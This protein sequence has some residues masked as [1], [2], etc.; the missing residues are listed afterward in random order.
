MDD[1][2]EIGRHL[3][4]KQKTV[5]DLPVRLGAREQVPCRL[6]AVRVPETVAQQR[7]RKL[8]RA[9][10]KKGQTPSAAQLELATWSLFV[11]NVPTERLTLDEALVLARAR[12]Q[13]ELLFKLW[14][15]HGQ[16]DTWRSQNSWRILCEVYAK[17]LAQLVQH[18]LLLVSCWEY[19]DRSLVKAAQT[20]A[21]LAFALT[22]ALGC[23]QALEEVVRLLQRCLAG[24]GRMNKR[25]TR[26]NTCQLLGNPPL[27][28][29][30]T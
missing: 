18:W 9:A 3:Q 22:A 11:T 25:K 15:S 21:R 13:I 2:V 10:Q 14:K 26:P 30:L 12:W 29:G 8:R 20:V 28:G 19:P 16:I 5:A 24:G 4:T 7:R 6:L 27:L 17:L 1:L 23:R